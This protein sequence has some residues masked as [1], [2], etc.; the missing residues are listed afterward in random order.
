M[1]KAAGR[2]F[3]R[4]EDRW[5]SVGEQLPVWDHVPPRPS[6]PINEWVLPKDGGYLAGDVIAFGETGHRLLS[7]ISTDDTAWTSVIDA[8]L[9]IHSHEHV[10]E[11]VTQIDLWLAITL[12]NSWR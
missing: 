9:A 8:A 5:V 11:W 1:S 7:L 6:Q 10:S 3:R 12:P 2:V 4:I